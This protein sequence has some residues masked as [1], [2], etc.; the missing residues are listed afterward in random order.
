MNIIF[1]LDFYKNLTFPEI[2]QLLKDFIRLE[3]PF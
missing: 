2:I 1:A 3:I